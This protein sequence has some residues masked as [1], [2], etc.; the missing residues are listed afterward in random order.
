MVTSPNECKNK[1]T[2][3]S[4]QKKTNNNPKKDA[5]WISYRNPQEILLYYT[6]HDS[7]SDDFIGLTNFIF[8]SNLNEML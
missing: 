5:F 7:V 8:D 2:T 6:L 4:Q 3:I 1:G